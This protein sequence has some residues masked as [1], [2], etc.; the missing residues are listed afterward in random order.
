MNVF[1]EDLCPERLLDGSCPS[2]QSLISLL[3]RIPALLWATDSCARF[4]S[5]TGAGLSTA[6][7]SVQSYIGKPVEALFPCPE[8]NQRPCHAHRKALEGVACSFHTEVGGRDLEAHLEP[9]R[10]RDGEVIGVVGVALDL[11]E[12]LVA[13]RALR[14]SEHS[15]R[16]L[17]EEAPCAICRCTVDGQLLQVNRAMLD[18]LGYDAASEGELLMRDLPLIFGS[19][20]FEALRAG[21]LARSD[22]QGMEATWRLRDGRDIQVIVSGRAIRDHSGMLSHLDIV[23]EDV[24]Q[25]KHL[26]E[27]LNQ[28]QKMQ[29]VGQLA[30]G[31]AHDFNNLLT[32]IGGHVDMMLARPHDDHLQH[33]LAEVR[34]AADRAASLTRQLLAFSRRQVL[35]NKVVNLNQVIH[36]L[37][38]MLARLIKENV[39][40]TFRPGRD[41]GCVR[42]DPSQIEQVLVNLTVNAQDAMPQGGQLTIETSN[43]SIAEQPGRPPEALPPGEYVQISVR[44]TGLGMD[45]EVQSR[46]FEPFFTTKEPGAGTGLGLSMAYGV[47][48]QSGGRIEVESVPGVGSVFYI[49]LP[50]VIAPQPAAPALPEADAAPGGTET[51]LLAEDETG[52]RELIRTYL[53]GLG[54][55]VLTASNGA[56]GLSVARSFPDAIDLLV[57]DFVMPKLGGRELARELKQL[58]PQLK[59]VFISGYAGHAATSEDLDVAGVRFLPKPLSMRLLAKTVRGVLDHATN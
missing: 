25:Q 28:A 11:T 49:Y 48:T 54:Y 27:Q 56:E 4:T 52:V 6:A 3:G 14:L 37:H 47:V 32:V 34:Q 23:A 38:T 43:V 15:Y 53:E 12:R 50:Q 17:V 13:E 29:A 1:L 22:L 5:L 46:I 42:A 51:I 30:G 19:Q 31:V 18:M 40:L 26:E 59:I 57:S 39:E 9:L 16:S 21:L 41:L 45:R 36:N 8:L 24:T 10:G 33:R 44:D 7:L 58:R 55:R 2:L 35:Q 20:G